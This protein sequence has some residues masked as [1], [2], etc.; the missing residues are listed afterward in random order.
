MAQTICSKIVASMQSGYFSLNI[1]E[2]TS[3]NLNRVLAVLVS[4][5][6]PAQKEVVVEHLTSVSIVSNKR[7]AAAGTEQ[8]VL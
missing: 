4:Y 2:S 1:D 8:G 6:S 7:V 5:Y 3:N